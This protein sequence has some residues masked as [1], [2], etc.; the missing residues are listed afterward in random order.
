MLYIFLCSVVLFLFILLC[1]G[2]VRPIKSSQ[3]GVPGEVA[4]EAGTDWLELLWNFAASLVA[5]DDEDDEEGIHQLTETFT[6]K[7]TS[8][9]T[10]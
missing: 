5:P 3:A 6:C 1:L 9:H 10:D 7:K 2:I 8:T 4:V